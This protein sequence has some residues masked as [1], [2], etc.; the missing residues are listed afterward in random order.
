MIDPH[1]LI[2]ASA[3]SGKTYRLVHHFL[4]ILHEALI[5][6]GRERQPDV[7]ERTLAATFTRAAAGEI[8]DRILKRIA[9]ASIDEK[10]RCELCAALNLK[11]LSAEQCE[12][13][14]QALVARLNRLR[15]GT[16]DSFLVR[17]AQAFSTELGLPDRWSILDDSGDYNASL[18]AVD[19]MLEAK[20]GDA[21]EFKAMVDLIV[22]LHHNRYPVQIREKVV[23]RLRSA[24]EAFSAG[25]GEAWEVI[26]PVEGHLLEKEALAECLKSLAAKFKPLMPQTKAGKPNAN[27]EKALAKL[28]EGL[29]DG[30]WEAMLTSGLLAALSVDP[31]SY[32]KTEF[33]AEMIGCL[34]PLKFHAG[35]AILAKLRDRN[36]STCALLGQY[37]GLYAKIKARQAAYRFDDFTMMLLD[38][39]VS[40]DLADFYYRLDGQIDHILLDEFQDTSIPQWKLIKPLV[41]EIMSGEGAGGAERSFFCVGDVKQTLYGWRNAEPRLLGVLSK[42]WPQ[43]KQESLVASRRSAPVIIDTVNE[44]FQALAD[45]AALTATKDEHA[46]LTGVTDI[47]SEWFEKHQSVPEKD[48]LA[49][50]ARLLSCA[51]GENTAERQEKA[52]SLAVERVAALHAANPDAEIAVLVRRKAFIGPMLGRLRRQGILASG[53]GGSPLADDMAVC[54][55]LSLLHLID[56]PSDTAAVFHVGNAPLGKALGLAE[57]MKPVEVLKKTMELRA[58][59]FDLGLGASINRW[60]SRCAAGCDARNFRRLG[61]LVEMAHGYEYDG[62]GLGAFIEAV[63]SARVEDL[64]ASKIRVMTIHA[65]K[66]REFDYVI[67]PDLDKNFIGGG[68]S[69]PA[70]L[71]AREALLG[72]AAIITT[73][74]SAAACAVEPR[75]EKMSREWKSRQVVEELC[76]LYVAVTRAKSGLEMIVHPQGPKKDGEVTMPRSAAGVL[77]AALF[78]TDGVPAD[79]ELWRHGRSVMP[80]GAGDESGGGVELGASA[81]TSAGGKSSAAAEAALPPIEIKVR[82]PMGGSRVRPVIAP[83]ALEG[84]GSI[85]LDRLLTL[86]EARGMEWG[87]VMHRWFEMIRW[88]DEPL[89]TDAQLRQAAGELEDIEISPGQL[90]GMIKQFRSSCAGTN[91]GKLLREADYLKS[92]PAGAVVEVWRERPFAVPMDVPDLPGGAIVRGQIDRV[93]VVR[94]G[95]KVIAAEVIDYK[96]DSVDMKSLA[97]K[98]RYYEPQIAAYRKAIGQMLGMAEGAVGAKLVFIGIDAVVEV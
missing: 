82:A 80:T 42:D 28:I 74:P 83:S 15:I 18:E 49:G 14:L 81:A 65:S 54:T 86:G 95:G 76:A 78:G 26:A 89:P 4:G 69:G 97:E 61:S 79:Q 23:E 70:V 37:V 67:L 66:G 47:W 63:K 34:D 48:N 56:H 60:M 73:R 44:I 19:E 96:S 68:S 35:A 91:V 87:T 39:D 29:G 59:I 98:R 62:G 7:V 64:E 43:I 77:R 58:E 31:P 36:R 6:E 9:G 38:A 8:I 72:E 33:C 92:A 3:G 30:Q 50:F 41:E 85:N 27:W 12:M 20:S 55:V 16:L 40:E 51:E 46:Y 32:Y 17:S 5:A 10:E 94:A 71:I 25:P 1:V 13:M 2:S 52:R 88:I 45:N 84:A 22:A 75:L 21:N 93:V 11:G 57:S 24:Q 90:A 53:E